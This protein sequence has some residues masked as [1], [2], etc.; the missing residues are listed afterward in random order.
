MCARA[1]TN[2]IYTITHEMK[3]KIKKEVGILQWDFL[4]NLVI[5]VKDH[6]ALKYLNY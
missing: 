3:A 6:I 2:R 1:Y 5:L 4:F